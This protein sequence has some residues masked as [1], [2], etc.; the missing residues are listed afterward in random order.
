MRFGSLVRGGIAFVWLSLVVAVPALGMA[1]DA[2]TSADDEEARALYEAGERAFSAGSFERA[3]EHFQH[4]YELSHRATLLY[5]IGL[6]ND[7][8]RR[9]DEAI[10]AFDAFLAS[11]P[12]EELAAS[13]R[14][15]IAAIRE[16]AAARQAEAAVTSP[17]PVAPTGPDLT[18]PIALVVSAGLVVVAGG[19]LLG[20]AAAE[21]AQV[22]SANAVPW[23]S[24]SGHHDAAEALAI[25]GG[26]ALGVGAALAVTGA[27]LFA[28]A[29]SGDT[30]V[31]IGPA[32]VSIVGSF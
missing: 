18:A 8:M 10:A 31:A 21:D 25:G 15:R 9:D 14:A 30:R 17:P 27:V 4:A 3:L 1:Q 22:Q 29:G 19:V 7:R 26:V 5:N 28:T 20:V 6:T 12:E 24:V 13:V 2:A 32:G 23:S 16:A 11:E